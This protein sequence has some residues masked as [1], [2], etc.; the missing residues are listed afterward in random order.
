MWRNT[1]MK[2]DLP[3]GA[4]GDFKNFEQEV[5]IPCRIL[6]GDGKMEMPSLSFCSRPLGYR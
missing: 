4:R 3:A 1:E 2:K 6:W 5:Y